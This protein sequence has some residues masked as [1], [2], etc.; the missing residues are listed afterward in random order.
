MFKNFESLIKL[1]ISINVFL[2]TPNL[3]SL[4]PVEICF[5]VSASVSGFNLSPIS[6]TL[7][8][9]FATFSI[10]K[11]SLNDSEF[12]NNIFCLIAYSISSFVLPTPEKTILFLLIP[13]LSDAYNSPLETTSAPR[14]SFFISFNNE[15]L[16]LDFTEKQIKGLISLKAFLKFSIFRLKFL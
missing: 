5:N 12:I 11:T 14:P 4:L 10:S 9:F 3:F 6:T 13:A 7:L 8:N 15:I 2:S 16:E 1:I